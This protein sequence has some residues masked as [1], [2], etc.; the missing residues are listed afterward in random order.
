M[1]RKAIYPGTFDPPTNGH[2]DIARRAEKIFD[3]LII[4]VAN[5]LNKHPV[6]TVE[7]RIEMLKEIFKNDPKIEVVR[8]DGLLADY[9]RQTRAVALVRGL[10]AVSDFEYELQ[11][12]QFNREMAGSVETVFFMASA[13]HLFVSSSLIK[14]AAHFGGDVSHKVPPVVFERLKKRFG[15]ENV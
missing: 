13:E 8:F 11:I 15:R 4:A 3:K 1:Q 12:A 10:R 14:E 7:E 9:A 2:L 5:N 6:F